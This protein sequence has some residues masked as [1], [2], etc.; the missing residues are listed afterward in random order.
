MRRADRRSE[1]VASR[2]QPDARPAPPDQ[3]IGERSNGSLPRLRETSVEVSREPPSPLRF[4][5][6]E[7][8]GAFPIDMLR[9]DQCWPAR[10]LDAVAL[11]LRPGSPDINKVR[12]IVLATVNPQ[13]PSLRRWK[14][15]DWMLLV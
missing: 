5:Y 13:A 6:V 8:Q 3:H 15:T 11:G 2:R 12:Q 9:L 4:F 10:R 1:D 7:G 14:Q